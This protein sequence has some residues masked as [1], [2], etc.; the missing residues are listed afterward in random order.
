MNIQLT[1]VNI[2]LNYNEIYRDFSVFVLKFNKNDEGRQELNK[3]YAILDD[4]YG[5]ISS[6][7]IME[8]QYYTLYLLFKNVDDWDKL[9]NKL[10]DNQCMT[11]YQLQLPSCSEYTT[12]NIDMILAKLLLNSIRRF[13]GKN[14]VVFANYFGTLYYPNKPYSK[15]NLPKGAKIHGD[16]LCFYEIRLTKNLVITLSLKTWKPIKKVFK[17]SKRDANKYVIAYD[18]N[19]GIK[20]L[21][22]SAGNIEPRDNYYISGNYLQNKNKIQYIGLTSENWT[23][24]KVG[25]LNNVLITLSSYMG[26]YIKINPVA[27]E[28]ESIKILPLKE[29]KKDSLL[30][31]II[32]KINAKG[33]TL[34]YNQKDYLLKEVT[35]RI[36]N[37]LRNKFCISNV[38]LSTNWN[39]DNS[40]PIKIIYEKDYY[41]EKNIKDDYAKDSRIQHFTI[42]DDKQI[43]INENKLRM[44]LFELIVKQSLVDKQIAET[45]MIDIK[46]PISAIV[47]QK[48]IRENDAYDYVFYYMTIEKDGKISIMEKIDEDNKKYLATKDLFDDAKKEI[49][50]ED[51]ILEGFIKY[52]TDDF[53]P[54]FV[55]SMR[56]LPDYTK[57]D[58]MLEL[59]KGDRKI[60][61]SL[62]KSLIA[63]YQI[64]INPTIENKEYVKNLI[65]SIN[66]YNFTEITQ[67][68][69]KAKSLEA[70]PKN[71]NL[72]NNTKKKHT[73]TTHL[74]KFLYE[75]T[76]NYNE[77]ILLTANIKSKNKKTQESLY[78]FESLTGIRY[79]KED[80]NY[81]YYVGERDL[82]AFKND[83]IEKSCPV[84]KITYN[85]NFSFEDYGKLLDI[86]WIRAT[87][88]PT[89]YPFIF[90]YIREW[91]NQDK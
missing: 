61:I 82:H 84:R 47:R 49:S 37:A 52:G 63:E 16:N 81:F 21:A 48:N 17:M 65:E 74:S 35:E 78:G 33:I 26:K 46:N 23:K 59:N 89:V 43:K 69:L 57:I 62:I 32:K 73:K 91:I 75:K 90:K 39:V 80:N 50:I 7:S 29:V 12:K 25:L 22:G 67:N 53:M 44:C 56:T 4:K 87:G 71:K 85:D 42:S 58:R 54:I 9:L 20:R 60:E 66:Q 76:K 2:A 19:K 14:M 11:H 36:K 27:Q 31:E 68:E 79:W 83:K 3:T 64:K 30:K 1:K 13:Y 41:I 40:Y 28:V 70:D 18:G 45:L 5:I 34:I 8:S 51:N 72:P 55:T 86:E 6:V 77:P 10:K 24:S 88:T 38:K 15:N